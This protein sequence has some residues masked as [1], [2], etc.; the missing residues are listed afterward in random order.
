MAKVATDVFA[1]ARGHERAELLRAA[2]EADIVPYWRPLESAAGPVVRMEGAERI[3]LGSNNYLGLT[4]DP[5]VKQ[6]ARDALER[7][8]T[9][10]TGSRFLN[11]TIDLHLELEADLAGWMGTEAAIVFTTGHQA[12]L[13]AIGTLLEP[14]DTVVVDSGDHA[15]ILDGAILSRARLRPFRH[16]RIDRLEHT[17]ERA[18][19]DGGGVLVAVDGVFSMEG[20]VAPLPALCELCDRFGARLMVDEA[21]ACGVLGDRGAGTSELLGVEDRV[22]LRMGT[23]S[24]SLASCGGFIA[25]PADVVEYLRISSRPFLFT[26]AAVPAAVGAALAAVRICRSQEGPEL[27]RRVLDNARY[28]H[29]GLSDL[30]LRVVDPAPL[31]GG[32][33]VLTPIVPV[34][35]GDDW[36]A[37]LLWRSLYDAGVYVNVALHPAVPPGGALLRTS[38]MA[39]HDRRDL[40]RALDVFARVKRDFEAEH[41][42]LP[43]R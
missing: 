2:R 35:V 11:G 14:G 20:D 32:G 33:D 37:A 21:H 27:F 13:G 8:G 10:L 43:G 15:S 24:K 12:N 29:R 1:K 4:G 7:Y 31:P 23:F 28:L 30:G 40:D 42:P 5:R 41:G 22:G 17:L 25:G 19:Q 6:A 38:V 34:T 16:N 39:T 9:G 36:K 18:A 3:M 26:A